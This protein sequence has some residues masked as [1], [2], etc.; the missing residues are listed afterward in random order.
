MTTEPFS[1]FE[2]APGKHVAG[3]FRIV[4]TLRPSG[5]SS[6]FEALDEHATGAKSRC[7]LVVFP[8]PLFEGAKQADEFRASWRPW[9][10]V[11]SDHV[12]AVH[13]VLAMPQHTTIVV[14]DFPEGT[15][16]RDWLKQHALMTPRQVVEL[17]RGLLEGLVKI[18]AQGLVH[19]DIKPQTIVVRAGKSGE[20][21]HGLLV[22]GGIT[23]GLWS[24]KHLGEH[25]ALIGTPFYA[26]IEQFGGESPDVLSDIYNDATV[27]RP[28]RAP[29]V[30]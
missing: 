23:A 1:L 15:P 16:L 11:Q 8:G 10:S 26:P 2:I 19:G 17:G 13:E 22:D 18:H 5:F 9:Q 30:K 20:A 4:K 28:K 25:T 3:R 6:A 21:T 7:V 24:A 29:A 14:T 12:V 27:F